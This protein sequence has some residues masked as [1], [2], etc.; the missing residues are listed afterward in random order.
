MIEAWSLFWQWSVF[1]GLS[2]FSTLHTLP[3]LLE[4]VRTGSDDPVPLSTGF[5]WYNS[6]DGLEVEAN[7]D[8]FQAGGAYIFRQVNVRFCVSV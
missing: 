8:R 1:A 5:F 7:E 6:S 4:S 2:P 3:G